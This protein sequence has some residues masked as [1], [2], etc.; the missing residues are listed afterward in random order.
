MS[1]LA[2]I[3][4]MNPY[5][6]ENLVAKV[7]DSKGYTT[8]VQQGSND[9]GVDVEAISRKHKILI[10]AKRYSA[11]NKIG[12]PDVRKY[13]TLYQQDPTADQVIIVTTSSFT[14]QAKEIAAEQ[15][16]TIINGHEFSNM[17]GKQNIQLNELSQRTNNQST[18][19]SNKTDHK[20]CNTCPICGN[21]VVWADKTSGNVLI[22]CGRCN[23]KWKKQRVSNN[24]GG[25]KT[26]WKGTSGKA[27][28]ILKTTSEWTAYGNNTES[29]ET[30]SYSTKKSTQRANTHST[31]KSNKTDHRY[32]NSC[33][34]CGNNGV[35]ADKTSEGVIVKC[36]G[37]RSKWK[38][39]RVSNN[40]G[41]YK[42]AWE[43]ISGKAQGMLKTTSEWTSYA[44]SSRY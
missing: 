16:V 3:R 4:S 26:L 8:S 2:T 15:N 5:N 7:W 23:S 35:S 11:D 1:K 25:Y 12:G 30:E 33:P 17:L 38:K 22:K 18:S 40:I 39:K 31:P 14:S 27:Q 20:F 43:G 10:Q 13:A 32:F 9:K 42:T 21:D 37:C 34:I 6:F 41:G 19:R 29:Q 44:D 24:V 36:K 28:G